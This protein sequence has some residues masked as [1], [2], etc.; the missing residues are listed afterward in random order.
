MLKRPECEQEVRGR[1][2]AGTRS[3][4]Q[5]ANGSTGCALSLSLS[6]RRLQPC[7]GPF[8]HPQVGWDSFCAFPPSLGGACR[9]TGCCAHQEHFAYI[10]LA[11][12]P[13]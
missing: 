12:Q 6:A 8:L 13:A 4:Q 3:A 1:R 10:H 7:R 9:R 11:G 5:P 2:V